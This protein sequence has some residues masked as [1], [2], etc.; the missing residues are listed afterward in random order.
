[1]APEPSSGAVRLAKV[2]SGR[3]RSAFMAMV[4]RAR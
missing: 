4:G 1:V 2:P 3:C